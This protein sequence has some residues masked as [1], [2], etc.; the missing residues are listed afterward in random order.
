MTSLSSSLF[1][2]TTHP[3]QPSLV[4]VDRGGGN[5]GSS[6]GGDIHQDFSQ[7]QEDSLENQSQGN[8][9]GFVGSITGDEESDGDCFGNSHHLNA[10]RGR[11]KSNVNREEDSDSN[12]SS[13]A[14]SE[15]SN[16]P[17]LRKTA[18]S[19]SPIG[20]IAGD[21]H[22]GSS[23]GIDGAGGGTGLGSHMDLE[24]DPDD[25]DE[26]D[27]AVF[28]QMHRLIQRIPASIAAVPPPAGDTNEI[29]RAVAK[30]RGIVPN[31][32]SAHTVAETAVTLLHGQ[33]DKDAMVAL[34][35]GSDGVHRRTNEYLKQT[36][37]HANKE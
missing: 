29:N 17:A 26:N 14:P 4:R 9:R 16:N 13:L 1:H 12:S 25:P 19:S 35:F 32:S 37:R 24:E 21:G 10:K 15:P 11:G 3:S 2:P 20:S 23:A 6:S 5:D 8:G 18:R 28:H 22:K 36:G 31:G 27:V 33:A 7:S 34:N 30:A